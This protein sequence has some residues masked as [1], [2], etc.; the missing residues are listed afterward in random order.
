MAAQLNTRAPA[1]RAFS[2]P[3]DESWKAQGFINLYITAPDGS[4]K[5]LGAIPLK[6][7]RNAERNLR[8]W[9][10][11]DPEKNA[12]KLLSALAIEYRAA[13]EEGPAMDFD[14]LGTAPAPAPAP[15]KK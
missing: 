6:D 5:K 13:D 15:E 10:G 9:L 14:A 12:A 11:K 8:E 2:R 7:S 1:A 4:K 3:Q